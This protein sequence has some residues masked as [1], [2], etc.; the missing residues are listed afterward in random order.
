MLA[1]KS[2]LI[3][4]LVLCLSCILSA[5]EEMRGRRSRELYDIQAQTAVSAI[6]GSPSSG[7]LIL[8]WPSGSVYLDT[9]GYSDDFYYNRTD[10]HSYGTHEML[11][12]EWAAAI[13]YDGIAA[14]PNAMWLTNRF[15]DPDWTTNSDFEDYALLAEN[16][17]EEV[18]CWP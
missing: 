1:K 16:W 15:V 13:Y 14:E 5:A 9:A 3:L 2:C 6:G 10:L 7:R 12:G 17:L 18:E 8:N 11:S 4:A